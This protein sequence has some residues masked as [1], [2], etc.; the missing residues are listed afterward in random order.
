MASI[1]LGST[2][3][4]NDI[5]MFGRYYQTIVAMEPDMIGN[6]RLL[7]PGEASF[8]LGTTTYDESTAAGICQERL[9][10]GLDYYY[11]VK[12]QITSF[13]RV[14][15]A[16]LDEKRR[17]DAV[18]WQQRSRSF[19]D[20]FQLCSY[21]I[22]KRV[23]VGFLRPYVGSAQLDTRSNNVPMSSRPVSYYSETAT[24]VNSPTH[25]VEYEKSTQNGDYR[26]RF[27]S[28]DEEFP[29][30]LAFSPTASNDSFENVQDGGADIISISGDDESSGSEYSDESDDSDES[31]ELQF[32]LELGENGPNRNFA[33]PDYYGSKDMDEAL[34]ERLLSNLP[35]A[36]QP[37]QEETP[38]SENIGK[39]RGKP[40]SLELE[41]VAPKKR[42]F[43]TM[44]GGNGG[45]NEEGVSR[46]GKRPR[47]I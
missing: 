34:W 45:E 26:E 40:L 13:M 6:E 22:P 32:P 21:L 38:H 17:Y 2:A 14:W 30:A 39:R 18:G 36:H 7:Q 41:D 15:D 43:L 42:D 3:S 20:C 33:K 23:N 8:I 25:W 29:E 47:A 35:E 27:V 16:V 9:D 4:V 44:Y 46:G 28:D 31:R 5:L 24:A 11:A 19:M 10:L 1:S 37:Y 12:H